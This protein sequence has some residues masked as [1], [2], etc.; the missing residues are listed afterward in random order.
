MPIN[1][2]I[3]TKEH[4]P[5]AEKANGQ[6]MCVFKTQRKTQT[7]VSAKLFTAGG[8]YG[9]HKR[10]QSFIEKLKEEKTPIGC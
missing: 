1:E 7:A 9:K 6:Y 2:V 4:Q 10:V 8:A 5:S 3:K